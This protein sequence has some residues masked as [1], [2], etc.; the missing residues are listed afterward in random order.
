[1]KNRR[2]AAITAAIA[3][4]LS[5]PLA[6]GPYAARADEL[7]DLQANNQAPPA[8]PRSAGPGRHGETATAAG[9]RVSR[10]QLPALVPDPRH[11]HL[12]RVG[13]YFDFSANYEITG[14]GPNTNA[15]QAGT[16]GALAAGIPLNL[17]GVGLFAPPAFNPAARQNGWFRM[18]ASES[19]LFIET[20]TPTAWG[21]AMTHLEADFWGCTASAVACSGLNRSTNPACSASASPTARWAGSWPGRTGIRATISRHCP[22]SSTFSAMSAPSAMPVCRRSATRRRFPGSATAPSPSTRCRRPASWPPRWAG[23][24]ATTWSRPMPTSPLSPSIPS[25]TPCRTARVV[26]NWE[27][28][29]GH[30]QLHGAVRDTEIQDGRFLSKSYLGSGGGWSGSVHP[31]WF[32]WSKDNLGAQAWIA[33]GLGH[34]EGNWTGTSTNTTQELVSNFGGPGLYGSTGG[35][36]TAAAASLIRAQTVPA[37]GGEV[38]YQH[39][40]TPTLRST[41]TFGIAHQELN[42]ALIAPCGPH[43]GQLPVQQGAGDRAPQPDLEPGGVH[44]HRLRI[45]LRPSPDGLEPARRRTCHRFR[46]HGEVLATRYGIAGAADAVG[47]WS[48]RRRSVRGVADDRNHRRSA[49]QCRRFCCQGPGHQRRVRQCA[50]VRRWRPARKSTQA[51]PVL[52]GRFPVSGAAWEI[53]HSASEHGS[54]SSGCSP[55]TTCRSG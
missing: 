12:A 20:R 24:R 11:R 32:G 40:W 39:W 3:C 18:Q 41:A 10:R 36:I 46:L 14:G 54:I 6:I 53:S 55:S 17:K 27:Q 35:P 9:H 47:R 34:Q 13:G 4:V 43:R 42:K 33:N 52:R 28:P 51:A 2:N 37:W 19:R 25:R 1:M 50:A 48:P 30:F 16:G 15:T 49:R 5:A 21:E 29:W 45:H 23:W 26:L 22:K 31:A 38:N 7:S 44:Q 8:T